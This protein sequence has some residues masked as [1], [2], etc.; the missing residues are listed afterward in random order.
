[1]AGALLHV[2]GPALAV[3][4]RMLRVDGVPGRQPIGRLVDFP[5]F[6]YFDFA[7][8]KPKNPKR[9]RQIAAAIRARRSVTGL[10]I[11]GYTDAIG[12]LRY[13]RNLS[14]RRSCRVALALLRL[15]GRRVPPIE[16]RA[17]GAEHPAAP[18]LRPDGSDNP[19]G[20]AKN[21]RA[22]VRIVAVASPGL[23]CVKAA[24]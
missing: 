10:R 23:A 15:I 7:K 3:R 18:N 5:V 12:Q 19:A 14:L 24:H 9:L 2:A 20:R 11:N 6:V 13:N 1:V 21:R 4:G 17:F 22:E 16:I 8:A